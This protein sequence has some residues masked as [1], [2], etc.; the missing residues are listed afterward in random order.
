MVGGTLL[1]FVGSVCLVLPD[2]GQGVGLSVEDPVF[3]W[4]VV[5]VRE[6]QV[7][8]PEGKDERGDTSGS[9]IGPVHS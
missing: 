5:V 3:E 2:D 9:V 4:Q 1:H 8:I 7:E 6:Q